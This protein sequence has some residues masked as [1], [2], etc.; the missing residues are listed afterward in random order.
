MYR[1]CDGLRWGA[2]T[3]SLCSM[4]LLKSEFPAETKYAP[5][6]DWHTTQH[7]ATCISKQ[8]S[9]SATSEVKGYLTKSNPHS[10]SHSLGRRKALQRR[11]GNLIP[12]PN[13]QSK[14]DLC[15]DPPRLRGTD[16]NAV[17]EGCA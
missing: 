17:D 6:M 2:V 1:I 5:L 8:A 9:I 14:R 7:H 3:D 16:V 12:Q 10:G 15:P 13:P 4:M 11:N